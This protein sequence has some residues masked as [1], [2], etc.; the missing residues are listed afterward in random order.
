MTNSLQ[1]R[2]N[3][4]VRDAKRKLGQ[5]MKR[6]KS[7]MRSPSPRKTRAN[8]LKNFAQRP[9]PSPVS[10]PLSPGRFSW[11]RALRRRRN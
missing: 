1:A 6:L 5:N 7:V 11:L 9:S 8:Y 10:H 2:R 3:A 4:V